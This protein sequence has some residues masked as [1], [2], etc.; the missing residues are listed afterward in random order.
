MP[1]KS[2]PRSHTVTDRNDFVV[3][4][5]KYYVKEE[6]KNVFCLPMKSWIPWTPLPIGKYEEKVEEDGQKVRVLNLKDPMPVELIRC[7]FP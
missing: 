4:S 1:I 3:N 5:I 2:F 7:D 6:D